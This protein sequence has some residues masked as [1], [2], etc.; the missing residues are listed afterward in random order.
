MKNDLYVYYSGKWEFDPA[1]PFQSRYIIYKGV[2]YGN[3]ITDDDIASLVETE[4][5]PVVRK[6]FDDDYETVENKP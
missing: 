6:F 5:L 4:L 3:G 2:P 1:I